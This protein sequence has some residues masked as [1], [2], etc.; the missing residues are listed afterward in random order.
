M[1]LTGIPVT[2]GIAIGRVLLYLPDNTGTGEEYSDHTGWTEGELARYRQAAAE[3]KSELNRMVKDS[4]AAGQTHGDIFYAH[5]AM[6]EDQV[7]NAEIEDYIANQH[8]RASDAVRKV[9][10]RYETA[11]SQTR[12]VIIQERAA[13]LADIKL[14]LLRNLAGKTRQGLSALPGPVVI[15]ARD[16]LP[17]DTATM[18]RNNVLAIVTEK[19]SRT[20]HSAIIARSYDI[21]AV[22][23]VSGALAGLK[24]GETVIVD[25][26]SGRIYS[27]ADEEDM[28]RFRQLRDRYRAEKKEALGARKITPVTKDGVRIAVELNMEVLTQE[29]LDARSCVDGVG[30]FRT[31]FLYMDRWELP[32]EEEQFRVYR[33]VAEAFGSKPVILR[34][35]DIGGDKHA[36]CLDLP[37][38]E[39]PFLGK[40]ALRLCFDRPEL[41]RTQLRAVLRASAYG[42]LKI[43]FPMVSSVEDIRRA[44]A[45]L[46]RAKEELRQRGQ[47]FQHHIPVGVMVEVPSIAIVADL[48]A[49]EVDFASIGSN[50]LCQHLMAADRKNHEVTEYCRPL[51]PAVLRLIDQVVRAFHLR[52]KPVSVC[53]EMGGDPLTALALIGLGVDGLSMGLSSLAPVKKMITS[54]SAQEASELVQQLEKRCLSQD[55]RTA[56]QELL[57]SGLR[58]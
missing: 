10:T 51:H 32:S 47:S 3:V 31:E 37:H 45:E 46:E 36:A 34:T 12:A 22:V 29:V 25:S 38:E 33:S 50:D 9:F 53:G 49:G 14:K 42:N 21:P 4:A 28:E 57:D 18:D 16:L 15:V 54:I 58:M 27:E 11:L 48:A 43:M 35:L 2:D 39:N 40:R 23:G 30:L 17:S 19:G 26:R 13:D 7:L 6:L 56:L 5:A 52:G 55:I 24:D 1:K 20:S 44:K 8:M 41:F